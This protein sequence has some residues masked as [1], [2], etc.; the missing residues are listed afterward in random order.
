MN[1]RNIYIKTL[2]E[3]YKFLSR[4]ISYFYRSSPI[5]SFI[6]PH[7]RHFLGFSIRSP[8]SIKGILHKIY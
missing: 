7:F 4:Q 6:T 1:E 5:N 8:A 3:I 2:F